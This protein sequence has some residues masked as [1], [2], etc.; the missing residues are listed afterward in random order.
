M[1]LWSVDDGATHFLME[2]FYR[3]LGEHE[4]AKALQLA[5]LATRERYPSPGQ[6]ASFA[7]FGGTRR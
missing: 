2:H 5:T 3:L 4:P 6:W 1:S 7:V